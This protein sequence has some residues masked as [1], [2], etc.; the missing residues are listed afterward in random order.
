MYG[1][2]QMAK[3]RECNGSGVAEYIG[4]YPRPCD[5]CKGE[6]IIMASKQLE[7]TDC[8]HK[9]EPDEPKFTLL[10]RD[11]A[12]PVCVRMWAAIREGNSDVFLNLIGEASNI[13]ETYQTNPTNDSQLEE[14]CDKAGKMEQWRAKNR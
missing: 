3:C 14:A 5:A 11:K 10:G 12:A 13:L 8:Y 9:A 2:G 4:G 7:M 6:G 1:T